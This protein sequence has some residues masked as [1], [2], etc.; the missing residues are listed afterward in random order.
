MCLAKSKSEVRHEAVDMAPRAPIHDR[1]A[2]RWETFLTLRA[3]GR[4]ARN[5]GQVKDVQLVEPLIEFSGA[6]AGCG[7]TP[8]L[9]A[10]EL[11]IVLVGQNAKLVFDVAADIV[12]LNSGRGGVDTPAAALRQSGVNLRQHLLTDPTVVPATDTS[13]TAGCTL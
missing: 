4:G 13:A 12:I 10:Q 8:Y 7:E 5:L 3:P 1:E 2:A 11:S 9:K 6:C